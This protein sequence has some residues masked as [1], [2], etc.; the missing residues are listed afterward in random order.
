MVDMRQCK[1]IDIHTHLHVQGIL[2][3]GTSPSFFLCPKDST[4]PYLNLLS[5]FPALT[6]VSTPTHQS[7]TMFFTT[8]KP[9]SYTH[10]TLPTIYSV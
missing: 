8:L 1:L 2:F 5:E 10:L 3:S 6:Q 9:V 7:N 4:D